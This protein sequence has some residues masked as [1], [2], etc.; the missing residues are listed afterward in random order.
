MADDEPARVAA[1]DDPAV[2]LE[3]LAANVTRALGADA[4]SALHTERDRSLGD[5]LAGRPG[6]LR[7]LRFDG[8]D[9]RMEVR[10]DRGRLAAEAARVS[11]GVVISR[12]TLPLG[13]WL[14]AF[15]GEVAAVAAV[16]SETAGDAATAARA[17]HA[18][19]IGPTDALVV[20]EADVPTGLLPLRA[21]IAGRVP[22]EVAAAVDRIAALLRETLPRVDGSTEGTFVV[23]STATDYLALP[24]DWAARHRLADGRT[25]AE[26]LLQQVTALEVAVTAIRDAAVEQD[27]RAVLVNGRFLEDRFRPAALD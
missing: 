10:L 15:A 20:S 3:A 1:S 16:A 26:A 24:R 11:G 21:A 27:A 9:E 13:A 6:T 14:T 5:R 2:L 7:T 23:V 8:V 22:D 18:L 19:G 17:L 12:R 4:A 25:P